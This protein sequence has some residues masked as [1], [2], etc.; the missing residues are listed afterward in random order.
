MEKMDAQ[1]YQEWYDQNRDQ[2]EGLVNTL[3]KLIETLLKEERIPYHS[4][5]GRVKDRDSF[6][7]KF[8]RKPYK[9]PGEMMD[10]AGLRIITHTTAE[11][12]R[13]CGL[14]KRE[15]SVDP[16]NSGDKAAEMDVDKVG[17]LSVHYVATLSPARAEL[18]EYRRFRGLRCEIQVRSLLQHAWAE[19]EHDRSYKFAGVLPK[20]I[21]RKFYL[22]AGTLELMDQE[23]CALSQ[24]IDSY[25]ARVKEQAA[26]GQLGGIAIDSTSLL[27]FLDE[28]FKECDPEKLSTA[29][30]EHSSMIIDELS[31]FGI[32]TLQQLRKLLSAKTARQWTAN[33]EHKY[34]AIL[35]DSMLLENPKNY[36]ESAWNQNWSG[37]SS[38]DVESWRELG[39][40]MQEVEKYIEIPPFSEDKTEIKVIKARSS[41]AK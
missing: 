31:N 21:Q 24:E 41:T 11:V 26:Q 32:Q 38:V 22:V 12:E 9:E 39:I 34:V 27:Q 23:F 5:N 2:Y 35:R 17:Y 40:D 15:F 29:F 10:I 18:R 20:E 8:E 3:E 37:I 30:P 7:Q 28:Y 16:E 4:V 33:Q 36:F 13:V 6:L 25:A 19:M 14:I 1:K